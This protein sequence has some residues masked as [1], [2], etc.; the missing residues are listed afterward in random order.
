[1]ATISVYGEDQPRVYP[2]SRI[3]DPDIDGTDASA[4]GKIIPEVCSQIV[5]DTKGLHNQLYTVTAVDPTTYK[6]TMVPTAIVM[7]EDGQ[8]DRVLSYGN[9]IYMLY[10]ATVAITDSTGTIIRLTRLVIDNKLAFFGHHG[11]QYELIRTNADGTTTVV[12]QNFDTTNKPTGTRV[13]VVET[14]VP[15]VRKCVNCYSY[16]TFKDGEQIALHIYDASG[17]LIA[18]VQLITK[19]ALI[20]NELTDGSNP[21]VAF[22]I[23]ANQMLDGDIILY[24]H[25]NKEE[26]A[27]YPQITYAD[28]TT[29]IVS[30]DG[31]SGFLYGLEDVSTEYAGA[32]FTLTAKYYISDDTPATIAEGEG[33]RF[34]ACNKTVRI[35]NT[36]KYSLSKISVIPVWQSDLSNWKLELFGYKEN[37]KGFS[38]LSKIASVKTITGKTPAGEPIYGEFVPNAF[39]TRQELLIETTQTP[40]SGVQEPY[41]QKVSIELRNPND[42]YPWFLLKD[43]YSQTEEPTYGNNTPPHIAPVIYYGP[44]TSTDGTVVNTYRIPSELFKTTMSQTATEVFLENFY[45]NSRPPKIGQESAPPIPTHFTVRAPVSGIAILTQPREVKKFSDPLYLNANLDQYVNS[46]LVVEFWKQ[47]DD[48]SFELLYGVPVMVIAQP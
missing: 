33:V 1:M 30:I 38:I 16:A 42:T 36:T 4:S 46:T 23:V 43:D 7:T 20:L 26:L 41:S 18:V 34:L 15:G 48:S 28:G 9:D 29:Q 10:Y 35:V 6:V 12:S 27:L 25:Q 45:F 21:I 2:L 3:Y 5:D 14:A 37:R 13:P 22:D 17:I 32:E 24:T 40:D 44:I 39:G 47:I 31:V 11:A 8:P 19:Q